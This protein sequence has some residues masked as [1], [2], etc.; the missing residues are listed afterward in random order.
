MESK[1]LPRL[2]KAERAQTQWSPAAWHSKPGCWGKRWCRS[3]DHPAKIVHNVQHNRRTFLVQVR[4][5]KVESRE[6]K[7]IGERGVVVKRRWGGR[8]NQ[9][10]F[11]IYESRL[12]LWT[13]IQS[14]WNLQLLARH[15]LRTITTQ[16]S[17][18]LHK[19][20]SMLTPER[21]CFKFNR[22]G[23]AH[24]TVHILVN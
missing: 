21:R 5:S 2:L 19:I 4:G 12:W 6:P 18:W 10:C 9:Q 23:D 20:E 13:F 15:I 17:Y 16:E 22:G 8:D 7:D 11:T 14:L 3:T 24:V 1:M